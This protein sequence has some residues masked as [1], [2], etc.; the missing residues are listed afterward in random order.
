MNISE[1]D[2]NV[3]ACCEELCNLEDGYELRFG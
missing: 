1:E 2:L 3:A